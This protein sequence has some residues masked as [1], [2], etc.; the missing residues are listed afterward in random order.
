MR[1]LKSMK[2]PDA[3]RKLS[4]NDCWL[5]CALLPFMILFYG[6]LLS[7]NGV[8]EPLN[9]VFNS[10]LHHLAHGQFDVDPNV[11]G[12]EG[13][14]RNGHVYSYWGITC[15]LIRLPLFLF[16]RLD[17]DVTMWSCLVAVCL[18]GLTRVRAVLLLRRYCGSTPLSERPFALM[19]AY[20]VLGGVA[21][22]YLKSSTYQ[23]VIFWAIALAEIFVYFAIK[24]LMSGQFTLATLS[25]MALAAGLA[26]LTRIS[27]G[28]GLC[29]AFGLLLFVLLVEEFRAR[30]AVLMRR[31]L[32]PAVILS[33]FLIV[34]G[35]VNY[36][37]WGKATTFA[38]F[39]VYLGYNDIPDG[40]ARA[41]M[42]LYGNFNV[43]RVPFGLSYY[44]LPI[45]ALRGANGH[46][47]FESTQSRLLTAEL[48]PS[49][50]FLT[51]LLP[52]VFIIFFAMDLW[53]ARPI[54]SASMGHATTFARFVDPRRSSRSFSYS[55]G[56]A[57][58][59]GLAIPC[60]L[61]VTAIY[62]AY[63]YHMEFYP[64]I[65]FVAF[66]GLYATVSNPTLLVR[67]N[68]CRR[69]ILA[70]AIISIVSAFSFL[71]LYWVSGWGSAVAHLPNGLA[72][73]YL[74]NLHELLRNSRLGFL[75]SR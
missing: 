33:T 2:L 18:I 6:A 3:I 21:V 7:Q 51:D 52:M 9:L 20:I 53:G 49:S 30:R 35:T 65:D 46:L 43:A 64:E 62:M 27:T 29:A 12:D 57:V 13:F 11:V 31:F 22:G 54:S 34:V 16:H 66:F 36:F 50:F 26:T 60:V 45:W 75:L 39:T 67:F 40:A 8:H 71:V 44:F 28:M 37:R 41:R 73:Y 1:I 59:I 24:G 17:L 10:M 58:A 19:L 5:Q 47:L 42:H 63:R 56:I 15:A 55:E 68:R 38:D 14:L 25:W 61:M 48:P 69:W 23:E 70:A 32:V 4:L 72:H 74:R